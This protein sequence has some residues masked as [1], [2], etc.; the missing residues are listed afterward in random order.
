MGGSEA[1]RASQA[2]LQRSN[3]LPQRNAARR[4]QATGRCAHA[5]AVQPC[6]QKEREASN[7]FLIR[8]AYRHATLR[9]PMMLP[10]SGHP[11]AAKVRAAAMFTRVDALQRDMLL[12][13]P[14]FTPPPPTIAVY[15]GYWPVHASVCRAARQRSHRRRHYAA[16]RAPQPAAYAQHPRARAAATYAHRAAA[17][18][19]ADIFDA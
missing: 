17:R 12:C 11:R 15:A 13:P 1:I 4:Q 16:R 2:P 5:A 19:Y 10:P 3:A 9:L 6:A 14:I 18:R 7:A 8:N